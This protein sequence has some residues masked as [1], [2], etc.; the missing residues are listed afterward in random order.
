MDPRYP[1]DYLSSGFGWLIIIWLLIITGLLIAV[2]VLGWTGKID[3]GP[4]GP[5]GPTGPTGGPPGLGAINTG[6]INIPHTCSCTPTVPTLP[7][8]PPTLPINTSVAF[9]NPCQFY[10]EAAAISNYQVI[11]V[12]IPTIIRWAFTNPL[13]TTYINYATSGMFKLI[14]G[15]YQLSATV[16][17]PAVTKLG[18]SN[19]SGIYKYISYM[20]TDHTFNNVVSDNVLMTPAQGTPIGLNNVTT[21][22]LN[23][24]FPV[25]NMQNLSI[26]TWHDANIPLEI[27]SSI[28]PP[29]NTTFH[30]VRL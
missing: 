13:N 20:L 14:P 26:L 24:T 18:T 3:V 19:V 10:S 4:T 12:G 5:A 11:P 22:T 28:M 8:L 27:G 15:R 1:T 30:L 16:I 25:T 2:A 6:I 7:T 21:L 9:C 23:A 17:Y 29:I